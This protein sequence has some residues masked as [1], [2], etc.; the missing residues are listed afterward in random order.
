MSNASIE[1]VRKALLAM[2]P[3]QT[4]ML[5]KVVEVDKEKVS[6]KVELVS[7]AEIVLEGVRLR[8]VD[9]EQDKGLVLFPKVGSAVL[10]GKIENMTAYYIAMFSELESVS[11]I[12]D[13]FVIN[14][15][16]LG[17][18]VKLKEAVKKYNELEKEINDL[19]RVFQSWT[20]VPNDGGA[21]LKSA[22]L[23]WAGQSITLTKEADLENEKVKQ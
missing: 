1:D 6:C 7:N 8:A 10:V 12:T 9:D 4:V 11:L 16:K 15:G 3:S 20:P 19:K 22:V 13:S 14:E 17:G 2:F 21:A 18:M 23:N 5:G